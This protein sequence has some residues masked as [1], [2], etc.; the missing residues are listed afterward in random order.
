MPRYRSPPPAQSQA[1]GLWIQL[2]PASRKR[3][4]GLLGRLLERRLT[5]TSPTS[6]EEG[7]ESRPYGTGY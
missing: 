7:D 3:L 6:E 5:A 2:P 1:L 4:L